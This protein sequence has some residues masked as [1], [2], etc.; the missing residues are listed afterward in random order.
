MTKNLES[1]QSSHHSS[2]KS[3]KVWRSRREVQPLC[4]VSC[5][6]LEYRFNGQRTGCQY[7]PAE[8]TRSGRTAASSSWTSRSSNLRTVEITRVKLEVQRPVLLCQ[9]K[10]CAFGTEQLLS[11]LFVF[12]N[13]FQ[14][15]STRFGDMF[16]FFLRAPTILQERIK[17]CGGWRGRCSLTL[18][19]AV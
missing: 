15:Q 12:N 18:L 6:N 3:C 14:I 17:K 8:S 13:C 11:F 10:V 19:W 4:T 16:F 9:L 2:R 1:F 5:L 7:E